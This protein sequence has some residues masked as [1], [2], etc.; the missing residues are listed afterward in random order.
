MLAMRFIAAIVLAL[1][2]F[3][4]FPFGK[5]A[6][7]TLPGL[8]LASMSV[9]LLIIAFRLVWRPR[10]KSIEKITGAN[11]V[12]A[13]TN[14]PTEVHWATALSELES[15]SRRNGLWAQ[16]FSEAAGN[17]ASAKAI[18]LKRRAAELNDADILNSADISALK[19]LSLETRSVLENIEVVKRPENETSAD[20][21][22]S[23]NELI[24]RMKS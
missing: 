2:S 21:E 6:L 1:I 3:A 5:R 10:S 23:M 20:R 12:V 19:I 14:S 18:Y 15:G 4:F 22:R 8:L 9:A 24:N 16:A 17:E 13:A 7:A 11:R